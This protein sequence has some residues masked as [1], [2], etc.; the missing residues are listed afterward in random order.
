MDIENAHHGR[1]NRRF[2]DMIELRVA[3]RF[4]RSPGGR[5]RV[6]GPHSGEAFREAILLPALDRAFDIDDVVV[7]N[8]DGVVGTPT[9][10]L[11]EAFGG[12]L[13][14]RPQWSLQSVRKHLRIEAPNSPRLSRFMRLA[15]MYMEQEFQR[16]SQH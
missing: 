16:R 2:N 3:D 5:Y 11:E 7:V 13:R 10:F 15:E 4:T 1:T 14:A 6:G 8:F 9:S 12:V